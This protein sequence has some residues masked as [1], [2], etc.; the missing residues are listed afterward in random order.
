MQLKLY[1]IQILHHR[2]NFGNNKRTSKIKNPDTI[3]ERIISQS[4]CTNDVQI[5]NFNLKIFLLLRVRLLQRCWYGSHII[6]TQSINQ[7]VKSTIILSVSL[8][9]TCARYGRLHAE[10]GVPVGFFSS[11]SQHGRG[12]GKKVCSP[13][14]KCKVCDVNFKVMP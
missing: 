6:T 10:P 4:P 1:I 8:F 9:T 3:P 5:K 14:K 7:S 11:H 13:Q 12:G 2:G